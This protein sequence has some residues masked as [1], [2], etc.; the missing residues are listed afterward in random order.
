M[1][2]LSNI[3]DRIKDKLQDTAYSDEMLVSRINAIVG[4]I[5]AG[6]R[7]D[8]GIIS[9]PL[10]DLLTI[11]TVNTVLSQAYTPLPTNYQRQLTMVYDSSGLVITP[12]GG[13]YY[14]FSK[15]IR[16]INNPGLTEAGSIYVVCVKGLN[17]YYQGIPTTVTPLGLHYYRKPEI[18]ALDGDEPEGIPNHLQEDLIFHGVLRDLYGDKIEDGQDNSGIGTKYHTSKFYEYMINLIDFVGIDAG[19]SYYGSN[20]GGDAGACDG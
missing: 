17:L 5:A 3:L 8:N 12:N 11:S 9:P 16:S 18:L 7:I 1:A 15:F 10:P 19:P 20:D 13:D 6:V 4:K 14:S 2:T